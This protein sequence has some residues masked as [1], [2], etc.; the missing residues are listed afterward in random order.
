ML[1][2][3]CVELVWLKTRSISSRISTMRTLPGLLREKQPPTLSHTHKACCPVSWVELFNYTLSFFWHAWPH[4]H[5]GSST[6][7]PQRVPELIG[8]QAL[9]HAQVSKESLW[10][11]VGVNPW[12]I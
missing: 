5:H 4:K 3:L 8:H 7:L 6:G 2:A 12:S 1:S 9:I 10:A 11:Q